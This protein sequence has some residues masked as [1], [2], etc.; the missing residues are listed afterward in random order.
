[1]PTRRQLLTGLLG[2]ATAFLGLGG[3][4]FAVEPILRCNVTHY[5]ITPPRWP[6]AL[7]LRTVILADIHA[8]N[9]SM[10]LERIEALVDHANGLEGD[11]ILLLGDYSVSHRFHTGMF[12]MRISPR[13]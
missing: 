3:Y 7:K 11:M 8:C 4:A 2:S 13:R 10:S 1:M 12:R 5:A 9:P 6:A